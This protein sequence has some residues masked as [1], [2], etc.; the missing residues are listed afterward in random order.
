MQAEL[1][2]QHWPVNSSAIA[3]LFTNNAFEDGVAQ[4]VA[5]EGPVNEQERA[6]AELQVLQLLN[7]SLRQNFS[8]IQRMMQDWA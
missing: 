1:Q 8:E 3:K 6:N 5:E 7:Y 4:P 2:S